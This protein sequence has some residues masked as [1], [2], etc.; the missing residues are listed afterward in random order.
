LLVVILLLGCGL[1]VN[2]QNHPLPSPIT[3]ELSTIETVSPIHPKS[4]PYQ[5]K[6]GGPLTESM[7]HIVMKGKVVSI[8]DGNT[9]IL[10]DKK[11][12]LVRL[13]AV[14]APNLGQAYGDIARDKL[15]ELVLNQKVEL[16][17]GMGRYKSKEWV[18][19]VEVNGKDI[20]Q[21]LIELGVARYKEPGSYSISSY[22][23]CVYR[24]IESESRAARRGLWQEGSY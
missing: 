14:D 10:K 13:E 12:H 2:A 20:N 6:C 17:M 18:G 21:T 9:L 24:I 5:D 19:I 8:I 11:K 4:F 23:A 1:S 3:P 15:R 16:L 22:T 7:Y